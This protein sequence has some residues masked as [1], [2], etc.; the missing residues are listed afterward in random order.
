[1]MFEGRKRPSHRP[2][3]SVAAPIRNLPCIHG[4]PSFAALSQARASGQMA[5]RAISNCRF[6][7]T[8]GTAIIPQLGRALNA[9]PGP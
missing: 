5:I 7:S 3:K 2:Y 8:N 4:G 1:M 9:S 6:N